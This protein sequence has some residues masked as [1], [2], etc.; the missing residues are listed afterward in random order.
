MF[1]K[2]TFSF[3]FSSLR[4]FTIS[5]LALIFDLLYRRSN[6]EVFFYRLDVKKN[7]HATVTEIL[8]VVENNN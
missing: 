1:L 6:N 2:Y 5:N 7:K 3:P 4:K 8:T